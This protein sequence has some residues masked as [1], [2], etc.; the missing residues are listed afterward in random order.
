MQCSAV[1]CSALQCSAVQC[2]PLLTSAG[3]CLL[4]VHFLLT[5]VGIMLPTCKPAGYDAFFLGWDASGWADSAA[6]VATISHPRGDLKKFSRS[7]RGL[8]R[9]QRSS[10]GTGGGWSHKSS[11]GGATHYKARLTGRKRSVQ[12]LQISPLCS[13]CSLCRAG[14][15]ARSVAGQKSWAG[16][17][18]ARGWEILATQLLCSALA[19]ELP[20]AISLCGVV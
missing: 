4:A 18:Q 19:C 8:K 15:F 14:C 10:P 11:G 12:A 7:T 6:E 2:S 3:T 20:T 1:Q 9:A 17:T 5:T 13:A 16:H